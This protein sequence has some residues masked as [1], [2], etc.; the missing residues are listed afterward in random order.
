MRTTLSLPS[1]PLGFSACCTLL[2]GLFRFFRLGPFMRVLH[3]IWKKVWDTKIPHSNLK[4]CIRFGPLCPVYQKLPIR[5]PPFSLVY[6][7]RVQKATCAIETCTYIYMQ[8]YIPPFLII[9]FFVSVRKIRGGRWPFWLTFRS[10]FWTTWM[11][12][13][14]SIISFWVSSVSF[15][16]PKEQCC[17]YFVK[18]YLSFPSFLIGIKTSPAIFPTYFLVICHILWRVGTLFLFSRR[19]MVSMLGNFRFSLVNRCSANAKSSI[20]RHVLAQGGTI[21]STYIYNLSLCNLLIT[22][23]A[24]ISTVTVVGTRRRFSTSLLFRS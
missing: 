22:A 19:P 4:K 17:M 12:T 11:T 9:L 15:N 14:F 23:G 3:N 2:F 24:R 20:N 10:T 6:C 16:T 5:F 13:T 18:H 8:M 21:C 1:T 7:Y